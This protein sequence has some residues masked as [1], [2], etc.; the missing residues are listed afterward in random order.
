MR[1]HW[2]QPKGHN[3]ER[4]ELKLLKLALNLRKVK[5][6]SFLLIYP[7]P[8]MS[9]I[10]KTSTEAKAHNVLLLQKTT[11]I[12]PSQTWSWTFNLW[13]A[14]HRNLPALSCTCFEFE[15]FIPTFQSWVYVKQDAYP[16]V[17]YEKLGTLK[18]SP[19]QLNDEDRF[20]KKVTIQPSPRTLRLVQ[21]QINCFST[22]FF[23]ASSTTSWCIFDIINRHWAVFPNEARISLFVEVIKI[24]FNDLGQKWSLQK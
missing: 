17:S 15:N 18:H 19:S 5:L 22:V 7:S 4:D 3:E 10:R 8:F 11:Q 2:G 21:T 16:H 24:C 20:E 14:S 23:K 13:N 9:K 12:W 6:L 1:T